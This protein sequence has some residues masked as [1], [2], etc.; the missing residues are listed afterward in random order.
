M[1]AEVEP[2]VVAADVAD[3]LRE[4]VKPE[5]DGVGE[6]IASI[7]DRSS[8]PEDTVLR[9]MQGK[10][11]TISLDLADRLLVACGAH[12]SQCELVWGKNAGRA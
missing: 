8:S 3:V 11:K 4:R 12:I 10:W 9:V 1:P 7:A 5:L 6:S 2:R